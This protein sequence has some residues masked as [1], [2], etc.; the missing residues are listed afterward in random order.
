MITAY[1]RTEHGVHH[2]SLSA[3]A[4]LP[5]TTIWVDLNNATAEEIAQT[6]HLLHV[7]I[8]PLQELRL[9]EQTHQLYSEKDALHMVVPLIVRS[10][11]DSPTAA[12]LHFILTGSTLVTLREG[13]SKAFQ[14]FVEAIVKKPSLLSGSHQAFAGLVIAIINRMADLAEIVAHDMDEVSHLV[15][16]ES[17]QR[18]KAPGRGKPDSWRKVLQ[19]L[20]RTARLNHRLITS[21]SSFERMLA[22]VSDAKTGRLPETER[23]QMLLLSHDIR[24]LLDQANASVNEATFLLDA[25]ASAISIE[26]N[27]VIKIFSMVS[28]VLMPPTMVA[29]IYGMNF[30]HMPELG[31]MLGYPIALILMIVS[32]ILPLWWFKKNGWF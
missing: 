19:G 1:H 27:N 23:D 28:V 12:S 4:P 7:K 22:F 26:Q 29:S 17:L 11:S 32:G 14:N 10:Q 15:F 8:P 3:G 24:R 6:A 9:L 16:Q 18:S 20:G 25:I 21:L 2:M 30:A 5:S 31:W 13:E